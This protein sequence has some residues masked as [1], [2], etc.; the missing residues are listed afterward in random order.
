MGIFDD[1]MGILKIIRRHGKSINEVLKTKDF[2][3]EKSPLCI[4]HY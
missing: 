1:D 4:T 3:I 2:L